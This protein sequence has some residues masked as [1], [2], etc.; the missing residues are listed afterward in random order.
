M[1]IKEGLIL[2][3]IER[4]GCLNGVYANEAAE[5]PIYNEIARRTDGKSDP[6][7]GDYDCTYFEYP[8]NTREHCH[9]RIEGTNNTRFEFT[10]Y[11]KTPKSPIWTGYGYRLRADILVVHYKSPE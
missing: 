4:G 7:E 8:N 11:K 2:Y 1:A 10:W 3:S 9:L 6:I 5:S